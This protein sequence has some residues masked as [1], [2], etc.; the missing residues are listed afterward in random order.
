MRNAVK[1]HFVLLK[2]QVKFWMNLKLEISMQPVCLLVFFLLFTLFYLK[3]KLKI[4]FLILLKEP[5]IKTAVLILHVT[6][7]THSLFQ[8]N[9]KTYHAWSCQNVCDV[10]QAILLFAI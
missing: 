4:D 5:Y 1:I 8:K 9:L 3:I 7:E 10:S 2:I 6:T